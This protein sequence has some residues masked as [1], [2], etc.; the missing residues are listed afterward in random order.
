MPAA[1]IAAT[2]LVTFGDPIAIPSLR[3]TRDR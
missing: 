1:M 2:L 3:S